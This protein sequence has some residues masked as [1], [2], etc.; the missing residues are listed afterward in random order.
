MTDF[1]RELHTTSFSDFVMTFVDTFNELFCDGNPIALPEDTPVYFHRLSI[2][3]VTVCKDGGMWMCEVTENDGSTGVAQSDYHK[4]AD[5]A[6]H[7]T[8]RQLLA[9]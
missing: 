8:K 2:G 3:M 1:Q 7:D 9:M 6:W 4:C 5:D